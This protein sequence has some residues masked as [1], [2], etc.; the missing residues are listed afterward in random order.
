[1]STSLILPPAEIL[2]AASLALIGQTTS[3]AKQHAV[4]KATLYMLR[5][6]APVVT[7]GGFLIESATRG[8]IV[9]RVD[10]VSGCSCEAGANGRPCWHAAMVEVL[11]YTSQHF[12]MP[13]ARPS[14]EEALEAA[15]ELFA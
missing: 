10:H 4:N 8:G 11:E 7:V 13:Q 12:T 5:G 9:H 3:L 2:G 6:V 15:L 14:Y 1:M